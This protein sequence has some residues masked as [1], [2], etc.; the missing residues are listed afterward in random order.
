MSVL[1]CTTCGA[2]VS[3]GERFCTN[4]G[5][6]QPDG[7]AVTGPTLVLPSP[8][9]APTQGLYSQSSA[10]TTP[11][12]PNDAPTQGLYPQPSAPTQLPSSELATSYTANDYQTTTQK[13]NVFLIGSV[14]LV[15]MFGL[16]FV[17]GIVGIG[18]LTL[19]GGQVSQVFWSIDSSLVIDE[20]IDANRNDQ[21]TSAEQTAQAVLQGFEGQESELRATAEALATK[22]AEPQHQS[23]QATVELETLLESAQQVFRDEFV[24]NR[25]N[26]FTGRYNDKETDLIEDGV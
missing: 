5:A 20:P 22:I 4:C 9:D 13:R 3:V 17:I 2:S 6:C 26:W 14:V 7:E 11:I 21:P 12:L 24:D 15:S 16:C 10:P 25:N 19:L 1:S 8:N 23:L 18:M